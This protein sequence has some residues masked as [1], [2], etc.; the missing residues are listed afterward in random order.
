MNVASLEL[1]KELYELSEW[2]EQFPVLLHYL[3]NE[4]WHKKLYQSDARDEL[5]YC[6]AYT[7]GY[8]LRKLPNET[9]VRKRKLD[10]QFEAWYGKYDKTPDVDGDPIE[11]KA[12]TPENALTK[13][14]IELFK[15]NILTKET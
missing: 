4:V 12:D 2:D 7:L 3:D 8:L 11:F 5:T 6:P 9:N 1:C 13:L 15:Q 14:T 10:S